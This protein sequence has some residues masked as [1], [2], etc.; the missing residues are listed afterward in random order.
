MNRHTLTVI[1]SGL[2]VAGTALAN[3]IIERAQ[4]GE[5][6]TLEDMQNFKK[7]RVLEDQQNW[8]IKDQIPISEHPAANPTEER[9]EALMFFPNVIYHPG[10]T[11]T[12]INVGPKGDTIELENGSIWI[13]DPSDYSKTLDW[14]RTDAIKLTPNHSWFSSYDYV[15]TNVITQASVR[16]NIS[17]PPFKDSVYSIRIDALDLKAR[18]VT[19]SDGSIWEMSMFDDGI[20]AKWNIKDIVMLGNNDGW[21]KEMNP[22][23][24]L[25]VSLL[26][27]A[28]GA[29]IK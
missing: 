20:I 8:A 26:E 17:M 14:M 18:R 16:A 5:R 3:P 13:V 2:L 24:M 22:Q 7:Q 29:R 21:W 1:L 12:A 19:L 4:L 25:N 9:L 27:H 28:R 23:I 10:T 15:L 11:H 6:T